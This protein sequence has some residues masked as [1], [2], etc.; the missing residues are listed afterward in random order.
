MLW[1][2]QRAGRRLLVSARQSKPSVTLA[3]HA[4]ACVIYPLPFVASEK[5]E[6]SVARAVAAAQCARPREGRTA[7][8]CR[9]RVSNI[10]RA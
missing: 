7:S 2:V 6:P 4:R 8:V 1:Q 10:A 3:V 9:P 5:Q